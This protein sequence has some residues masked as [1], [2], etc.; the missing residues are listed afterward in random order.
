MSV[1]VSSSETSQP[2]DP[3]AGPKERS[4]SS[5]IIYSHP[6]NGRGSENI[7]NSTDGGE[8]SR[9]SPSSYGADGAQLNKIGR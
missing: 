1:A 3:Q 6:G 7:E 4:S 9:P 8:H 5:N 2:E